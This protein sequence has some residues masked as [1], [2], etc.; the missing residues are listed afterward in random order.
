MP[1]EVRIPH[2]FR[3]SAKQKR[4]S[5]FVVQRIIYPVKF[6]G[7]ELE[8]LDKDGDWRHGSVPSRGEYLIRPG[9]DKPMRSVRAVLELKP[10]YLAI[11]TTDKATL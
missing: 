10:P 8:W 9:G 7:P 5:A 1:P 2:P 4:A 11:V 6:N 3:P